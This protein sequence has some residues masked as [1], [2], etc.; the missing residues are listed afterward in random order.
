MIAGVECENVSPDH[1]PFKGKLLTIRC[2]QNLATL[3]L[4][5]LTIWL[6]ASKLKMCHVTL[7]TP[8]SGVVCHPYS[9]SV[10]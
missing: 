5:V 6:R 2:L 9:L 8:I 3:A 10:C 7:T 1:A 4:A